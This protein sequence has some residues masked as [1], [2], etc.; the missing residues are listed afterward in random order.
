[1]AMA[2]AG[3]RIE[4][5]VTGE[6]VVFRVTTADSAGALLS[7]DYVVPGH[8]V[9]APP[10]VHRRQEERT[11]IRAGRLS[12]RVGWRTRTAGPGEVV[13]VPAGVVHA[14]RNAA[15][16]PLHAIVEFRPALRT[17]TMLEQLFALARAG[18]TNSRGLPPP[19]HMAVLAYEYCDEGG[20]PLIPRAVQRTLFAGPAALGRRRGYG[21]SV[22][23]GNS[24][25]ND[26]T[27]A[28]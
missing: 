9:I 16:E 12:G 26:R 22:S 13:T 8:Y 11:E 20:L 5:P 2:R 28:R 15:A 7:F 17:E 14:W 4:N 23:A 18:K 24:R 19:L 6:Q 1:M 21:T 3:D 25:T 10:H 27:A